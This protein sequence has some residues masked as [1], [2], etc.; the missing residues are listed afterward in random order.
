M[1][2]IYEDRDILVVYKEAGLAVE[3]ARI[4]SPD[5]VSILK[6]HLVRTAAAG[7]KGDPSYLAVVHRL[8]QPVEGIMVFAKTKKAGAELSK[9]VQNGVMEKI[10]RAGVA[11]KTESIPG[12][13]EKV[14]LTDYLVR[15]GRTN[16]TKVAAEGTKDAKKAVLEYTL[17]EKNEKDALLEV[18][19]YT[20]RPH[21]IRVQLSHAG[22]PIRG[23]RKYGGEEQ[24]ESELRFPALKA[25]RLS[26]KHPATGKRM[27]FCTD[28]CE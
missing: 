12:P 24:K 27:S 17:L 14:M 11:L 15:D 22:M 19:L 1:K 13:G 28:D 8:D 7:Q 2:I 16:L 23:D 9:Q 20:G 6:K 18:H 5:L 3:S 25:Y 21:Q 4:T 10:Y 26:F